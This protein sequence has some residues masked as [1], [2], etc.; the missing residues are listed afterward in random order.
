[1]AVDKCII[2]KEYETGKYTFKQLSEK[3]NVK[4]GTIKS[5]AKRDKDIG[6][7]WKKVAIKTKNQGKKDATKD[8]KVSWVDI[9]N[10]YVTDIRKKPRTYN[11]MA[12]KYKI[13]ASSIEKYALENRW[14][15]KR[16]KYAKIVKKKAIEK[17]LDFISTDIARVTA[18]HFKI[19]DMLLN[20]LEKVLQDPEDLYKIVEKLRTGYGPGE[21]TEEIVTEVIDTLN[22]KKLLNYANA[23]TKLQT[24]QRQTL[25]IMD[26]D[27]KEK[28]EIDRSKIK[29]EDNEQQDN[30]LRDML[31]GLKKENE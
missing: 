25:G 7:P 5:W 29:K 19:A 27:V 2:R 17:S 10:E 23:L 31:E 24:A 26:A 22:D 28:L 12:I 15:E 16:E 14:G 6:Q 8:K 4:E 11:D 20:Q 13:S 18:K 1:M 3:F 30:V 21:F 9:E